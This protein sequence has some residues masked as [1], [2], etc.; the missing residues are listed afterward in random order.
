MILAEK[1]FHFKDGKVDFEWI[2]NEIT[3]NNN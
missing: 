3:K 2:K 1:L